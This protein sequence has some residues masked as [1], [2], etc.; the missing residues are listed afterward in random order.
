[1]IF[2]YLAAS[3]LFMAFAEYSIHR[4]WQHE[5][6]YD[7]YYRHHSLSDNDLEL[8]DLPWWRALAIAT[9]IAFAMNFY[10]ISLVTCFYLVVFMHAILW[11]LL[12]RAFHG[13]SFGGIINRMPGFGALYRPHIGHHERPDRNYGAVFGPLVDIVFRTRREI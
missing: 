6:S 11:T 8:I 1:M 10:T 4:W 5:Y 7:H 12:H 9:P 3:V 13:I 2:V